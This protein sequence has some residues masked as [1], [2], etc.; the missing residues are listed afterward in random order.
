MSNLSHT[1]ESA[2]KDIEQEKKMVAALKRMSIGQQLTYDPDLPPPS[3]QSTSDEVLDLEHSLINLSIDT[4]LPPSDS[5]PSSSSPYP[6]KLLS[7]TFTK[8]QSMIGGN[9]SSNSL[10]SSPISPA[11]ASEL[12]DPDSYFDASL[13]SGTTDPSIKHPSPS[14]SRPATPLSASSSPSASASASSVDLHSGSPSN[15]VNF[16]NSQNNNNNNLLW[17]PANM[18][19][20]V[21][22]E[23]FKMH[24]KST[25]EEIMERQI[26]RKKSL[27]RK[28]SLSSS[29]LPDTDTNSQQQ[30]PQALSSTSSPSTQQQQHPQMYIPSSASQS[31]S[32]RLN[33]PQH[34]NS[35]LESSQASSSNS[36]SSTGIT[37]DVNPQSAKRKSENLE[38]NK[39][40]SNPSLRELSTELET[41][42]KLAGIDASDA[43]TLARTLSSNSIGYTSVERLAMDELGGVNTPSNSNNNSSSSGSSYAQQNLYLSSPQSSGSPYSSSPYHNDPYYPSHETSSLSQDF[44]LKRARR[45]DYRTLQRSGVQADPTFS[46][47]NASANAPKRKP[48]R[49][50]QF[51]FRVKPRDSSQNSTSS[52]SAAGHSFQA[53]T[54]PNAS[55]PSNLIG[56][57]QYQGQNQNTQSTFSSTHLKLPLNGLKQQ[58]YNQRQTLMGE[59]PYPTGSLRKTSQLNSSFMVGG[60]PSNK[61]ATKQYQKQQQLRQMSQLLP[62]MNV[63]VGMGINPNM[64]LKYPKS[65]SKKQNA[66]PKYHVQNHPSLQQQ[67]GFPLQRQGYPPQQQQGYPTKQHQQLAYPSQPQGYQGQVYPKQGN[68]HRLNN[69]GYPSSSSVMQQQQPQ[70]QPSGYQPQKQAQPMNAQTAMGNTAQYNRSTMTSVPNIVPNSQSQHLAG[71]TQ[72]TQQVS[73]RSRRNKGAYAMNTRYHTTK[74]PG[75]TGYGAAQSSI[76]QNLDLL[77]SEINEFK[78]T[79]NKTE[80]PNGTFD[81]TSSQQASMQPEAQHNQQLHQNVQQ[82]QQVYEKNARTGKYQKSQENEEVVDISFDTSTQDVSYEDTLGIEQEVLKELELEH[83]RVSYKPRQQQDP[84]YQQQGMNIEET[85]ARL[86]KKVIPLGTSTP[87]SEVEEVLEPQR[88]IYDGIIFSNADENQNIDEEALTEVEEVKPQQ[89]QRTSPTKK[90]Y[91]MV[92]H[93]RH[94]SDEMEIDSGLNYGIT[95]SGSGVKVHVH[96]KSGDSILSGRKSY[97]NTKQSLEPKTSLEKSGAIKASQPVANLIDNPNKSLKMKKSWGWLRERSASFSSIESKNLATSP[98]IN[99]SNHAGAVASAGI[100]K[101]P[102]K[103][104]L[105]P[106]SP[107]RSVSNPE[108]SSHLEQDEKKATTP[109]ENMITKLFKKKKATASSL[110]SNAK[111]ASAASTVNSGAPSLF[112]TVRQESTTIGVPLIHSDSDGTLDEGGDSRESDYESEPDSKK[113][114]GMGIFKKKLKLLVKSERRPSH[115]DKL[116]NI[117][118]INQSGGTKGDGNNRNNND[119]PMGSNFGT[120]RDISNV[121]LDSI[122]VDEIKDE[123]LSKYEDLDVDQIEVELDANKALGGNGV[124]NNNEVDK[125]N[126]KTAGSNEE[127]ATGEGTSVGVTAGEESTISVAGAKP[128]DKTG[129]TPSTLDIQ[130]K[131][132]KSIKRTSRANQPIQFTD[133]AFGF[134]LPPPSQSTLIMLD[135]RFPVHVERAIY[136]LSHL[137]LANPKRS[138]REQVLLSNFMYAYLNLVDHTLHLEQ[139]QIA[140]PSGTSDTEHEEEELASG[141]KKVKGEIVSIDLSVVP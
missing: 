139:Q 88:Q 75:K 105:S 24:V 9:N 41:L 59:S 103:T 32:S 39:R 98:I 131:I 70:Q 53:D 137:K 21:N 129:N 114:K 130:E 36:T 93:S 46:N 116:K 42:S 10:V 109:K 95:S 92:S 56:P 121:E 17:V 87:P 48:S 16:D 79:L 138:L 91:D 30:Q 80:G 37:R 117:L 52:E 20:Q 12:D 66:Y 2:A 115:H 44:S 54:D 65:R 47:A 27:S 101:T 107:T 123:P 13:L 18:H 45:L 69:H 11:S 29:S 14:H 31:S 134:P 63:S 68:G 6:S 61:P 72:P 67:Q 4:S 34:P 43:V 127:D 86:E 76:N 7:Q 23:K 111:E 50:S 82:P 83:Q 118:S 19:P 81:Q 90:K 33:T 102:H 55:H 126:V 58:Q 64:N 104:P 124:R 113:R 122:A 57:Y 96:K 62:G 141:K 22:P 38:L 128:A 97:E 125:E 73:P 106:K 25:M 94:E 74:P 136:R 8:N 99:N 78:E 135:Y 1:Y 110:N 26:N 140:T 89:P 40:Y 85:A 77:R 120:E 132:K 60:Y 15:S 3:V 84:R 108:I 119:E 71:S 35:V 51:L 112:T 100:L 5:S 133:S 49:E 28:S